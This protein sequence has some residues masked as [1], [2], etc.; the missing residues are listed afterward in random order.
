MSIPKILLVG[1]ATCGKDTVAEKLTSFGFKCLGS[2]TFATSKIMMP[3][4]ESIGEPY[5]SPEECYND[6]INHRATWYKQIEL[7]NKESWTRITQ[8]MFD[9]GYNVYVGMRSISELNASRNLYDHIVWIDASDRIENEDI[10]SCTI[11][12]HNATYIID[13]NGTMD[14]L[15]KEVSDFINHITHIAAVRVQ[16]NELPLIVPRGRIYFTEYALTQDVD[17]NAVFEK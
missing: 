13:N 8:E 10:S 14:E 9:E 5:N 4:F 7:Y 12:P 2:S 3:Y 11:G 6:R 15:N 16:Y 1:Y 17:E